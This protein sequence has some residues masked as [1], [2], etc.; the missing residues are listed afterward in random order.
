VVLL[1][2]VLVINTFLVRDRKIS[3]YL[4]QHYSFRVL[5]AKINSTFRYYW[6]VLGALTLSFR[7]AAFRSTL[8]RIPLSF[9]FLFTLWVVSLLRV[10]LVFHPLS[11]PEVDL[12][13]MK[14]VIYPLDRKAF[15]SFPEN[16]LSSGAVGV[17][18]LI[19]PLLILL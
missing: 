14:S 5:L 10:G 18:P 6:G 12:G 9:V 4:S 13:F 2:W 17:L 3:F 16:Q 1:F 15:T 11:I 19:Y 8:F 7:L